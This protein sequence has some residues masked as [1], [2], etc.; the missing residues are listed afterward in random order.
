MVIFW[1]VSS[2]V[3]PTRIPLICDFL[4]NSRILWAVFWA[5]SSLLPITAMVRGLVR[6]F[7]SLIVSFDRCSLLSSNS[8]SRNLLGRDPP[9]R[10]FASWLNGLLMNVSPNMVLLI[11]C[12]F[13][14]FAIFWVLLL[15]Y[16]WG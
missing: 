12:M 15:V 3:K 10:L 7:I 16:F 5:S 2:E 11:W 9:L 1:I 4:S 14:V 13:E 6:C 8:I